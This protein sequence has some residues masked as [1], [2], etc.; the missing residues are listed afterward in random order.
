[1]A[2]ARRRRSLMDVGGKSCQQSG[3]K[4]YKVVFILILAPRFKATKS[5]KYNRNI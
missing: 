1:M 2:I 4:W 5:D 3:I